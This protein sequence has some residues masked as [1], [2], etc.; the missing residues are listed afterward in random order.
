[1]Y[2]F[3]EVVIAI[4]GFGDKNEREYELF[5]RV[6]NAVVSSGMNKTLAKGFDK[7]FPPYRKKE[8]RSIVEAAKKNIQALRLHNARKKMNDAGRIKTTGGGGSPT[9]GQ[10]VSQ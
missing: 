7:F 6:A 9:G 2:T 1:M 10:G 8:T 4:Y 3:R 5:R